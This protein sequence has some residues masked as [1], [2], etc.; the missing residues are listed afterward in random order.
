M[1]K[2]FFYNLKRVSIDVGSLI[3][4]FLIALFMPSYIFPEMAKIG[5]LSL[6]MSKFIFVSAGIVHAHISRKLL[7]P[8]ID[9]SDNTEWTNNLMIIAW[10]VTIIF[11]WA[12]GG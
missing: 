7:F 1:L 3:I 11:C 4:I 2:D 8:Y 6:F 10:Y 9:F 5:L 12:R